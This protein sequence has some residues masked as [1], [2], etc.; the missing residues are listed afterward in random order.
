VYEGV[1]WCGVDLVSVSFARTWMTH[2][3]KQYL[4]DS[5]SESV[6]DGGYSRRLELR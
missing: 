3:P 6:V 4:V 1:R 2:L 5:I